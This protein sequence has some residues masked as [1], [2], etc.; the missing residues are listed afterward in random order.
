[1]GAAFEKFAEGA[2]LQYEVLERTPGAFELNV[3][4][5]RYATFYRELRAP[6]LGFLLT[7]SSDFPFVEGFGGD[8][9][10]TRTQTIM[11]GA[12]HCDFRYRVSRKRNDGDA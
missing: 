3:T 12:D 9:Q 11:E 1:V 8:V 4:E 5:C 6:E 2:A 10:L 7:C